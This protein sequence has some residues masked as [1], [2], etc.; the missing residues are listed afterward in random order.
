M[1]RLITYRI[2]STLNRISPYKYLCNHHQ[3]KCTAFY[4]QTVTESIPTD[5]PII[6][7]TTINPLI[8]PTI[9]NTSNTQ[10]Q[11]ISNAQNP[12]IDPTIS[13][14]S[15]SNDTA[16]SFPLLLC[17]SQELRESLLNSDLSQQQSDAL[18][19]TIEQMLQ[20]STLQL[21][22]TGSQRL[23]Q[24]EEADSILR[25]ITLAQKK[26]LMTLTLRLGQLEAN[27]R[28][29]REGNAEAVAKLASA[30]QEV[31]TACRLDCNVAM[32][33]L[34][35]ERNEEAQQVE[36]FV[37][38]NTGHFQGFLGG[39]RGRLEGIKLRSF[40]MFASLMIGFF[41]VSIIE[42]ILSKERMEQHQQ[43]NKMRSE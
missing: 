1:Y 35:A 16:S 14:A 5:L 21:N 43:Y 40:S 36:L 30:V 29:S 22:S 23:L 34:R 39:F 13:N 2:K 7:A 15:H 6:N 18:L 25:A 8:N 28:E 20:E 17:D 31:A 10:S 12:L 38:R 32:A 41:G 24:Q 33:G 19:I 4:S 26:H 3:L 42:R 9:G 37:Q 27:G 11:T